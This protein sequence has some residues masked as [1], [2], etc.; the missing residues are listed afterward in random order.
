EERL[1]ELA[2]HYAL[3]GREGDVGKAVDYAE[4][5]AR[6]AV[7]QLAYEDGAHLYETAL[8]ALDLG[9]PDDH[10]RG[11][12]LL[13]LGSARQMTW[14]HTLARSAFWEAVEVARRRGDPDLLARAALGYAAA[15]VM[16][17]LDESRVDVVEEAL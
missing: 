15:P 12:L 10:R 17:T 16:G 3:A 13:A 1:G 9:A 8:R 14:D 6:R 2:H 11:D 5:A 7:A 4:R